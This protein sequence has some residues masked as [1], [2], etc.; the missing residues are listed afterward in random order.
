MVIIGSSMDIY[1]LCYQHEYLTK[2]RFR[3]SVQNQD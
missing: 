1:Y 3:Q 2:S